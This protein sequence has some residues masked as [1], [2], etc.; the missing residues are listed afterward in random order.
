[1]T[2]FRLRVKLRMGVGDRAFALDVDAQS[3][4]RAIAI[5]GPSGSGKSTFLATIAGLRRPD[6]GFLAIGDRVFFDSTRSL[7]V[8]ADARGIG[9][10]FQDQR[11]FPHL[12]V[13]GNVR[14]GTQR[15]DGIALSEEEIL[16]ALELTPHRSKRPTDLSGGERQRVALARALLSR[17][18]L[19]L[20]DEPFSSLDRRLRERAIQLVRS[21]IDS[22]GLPTILVT[23]RMDEALRLTDEV[24]ALAG[25]RSLGQGHYR[26]LVHEPA[27]DAALG[28]GGV[29]NV[30]PGHIT[31]GEEPGLSI[32]S[33]VGT[34]M[35]MALPAC[36]LP[37]GS[38]VTVAFA[39]REVA[40]ARERIDRISIRNQ[41]PGRVERLSE[42]EH[43][44]LVQIA[45]VSGDR[46]P[47]TLLAETSRR[48][49]KE[50]GLAPGVTVMALV[51][52]QAIGLL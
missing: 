33:L 35:S 36:E 38:S 49:V 48:A 19:L 41:L 32:V 47:V 31:H 15:A 17:P 8:A 13:L 7:H 16:D 44:V 10:A 25:G 14:Y 6:E 1:M 34:G 11:L 42:H 50:L 46:P 2:Q 26:D 4:A 51:K 21:V 43:G 18:R 45:L 3:D 37:S 29:I 12:S 24:I 27:A 20:L 22:K 40:V 23:H 28:A 5:V 39:A 9:V 30:L 52:S